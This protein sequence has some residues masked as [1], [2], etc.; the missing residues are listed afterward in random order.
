MLAFVSTGEVNP[1]LRYLNVLHQRYASQGLKIVGVS[2]GTESQTK[3]LSEEAEIAFPLVSDE[4]FE[5]HRAFRIHPAHQHG[6]VIV[7]DRQGRI[8]FY[9]LIFLHEDELRQLAEKYALGEISYNPIEAGLATRFKVGAPLPELSVSSIDGR[10]HLMLGKAQAAD[11]ALVI[12]NASC[13][14]CQLAQFINELGSFQ[15][16]LSREHPYHRLVVVFTPNFDR[17]MLAAYQRAGALPGSTYLLENG[18]F[19]SEYATRYNEAAIRPTV[20]MTGKSG[21]IVA[22]HSLQGS[23]K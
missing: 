6:G 20:I 9:T 22:V 5:L 21:E 10:K 11:L 17:A 23:V 3:R 4:G 19:W 13:S 12:F 15:D 1:R 7:L 8:D 16:K 2:D 18:T 14:S